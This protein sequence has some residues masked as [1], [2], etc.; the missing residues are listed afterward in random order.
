MLVCL[1]LCRPMYVCSLI[2]R[3]REGRLSPSFQGA[4]GMVLRA[5]IS[6]CLGEKFGEGSCAE[7]RKLAFFFSR[8]TLPTMHHSKQIG[9]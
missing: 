9:H 4:P 1:S 7:A 5:K 6:A 3:E 8:G 2:T